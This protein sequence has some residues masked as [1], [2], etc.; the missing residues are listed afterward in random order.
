LG[1]PALKTAVIAKC[2]PVLLQA[3]VKNFAAM[4]VD[5]EVHLLVGR[6]EVNLLKEDYFLWEQSFK[7]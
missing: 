7:V 6:F 2:K 3:I 5:K 1:R 4:L